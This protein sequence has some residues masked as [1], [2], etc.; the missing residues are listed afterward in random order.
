MASEH[1]VITIDRGKDKYSGLLAVGRSYEYVTIGGQAIPIEEARKLPAMI[2]QACDDA[3][4][5]RRSRLNARQPMTP[6]W[7]VNVT[8]AERL[9]QFARSA[10]QSGA[11]FYAEIGD[12]R[13][14]R[15]LHEH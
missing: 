7:P 10:H 9:R 14:R 8:R 13:Q 6:G 3:R 5:G 15:L 4:N 1:P 12:H 11:T 2:S